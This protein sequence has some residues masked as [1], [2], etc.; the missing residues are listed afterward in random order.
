MHV[1]TDASVTFSETVLIELPLAGYSTDHGEVRRMSGNLITEAV[2]GCGRKNAIQCP[3][4]IK[5]ELKYFVLIHFHVNIGKELPERIGG[6][7]FHLLPYFQ[8]P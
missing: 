2:A 8:D 5:V 3:A 1:L 4:Y 6:A 7:L